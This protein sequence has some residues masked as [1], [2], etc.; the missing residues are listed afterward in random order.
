MKT[1]NR[2]WSSVTLYVSQSQYTMAPENY[3]A[4]TAFIMAKQSTVTSVLSDRGNHNLAF[5]SRPGRLSGRLARKSPARLMCWRASRLA[6][7]LWR[8]SPLAPPAGDVC[9]KLIIYDAK[10]SVNSIYAAG[11][12]CSGFVSRAWG[13][14][15]RYT[16]RS[17]PSHLA[18]PCDRRRPRDQ[19]YV[20][21]GFVW[22]NSAP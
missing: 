4:E 7:Q 12:D 9:T 6:L 15:A 8:R 16:T 3:G 1:I 13:G 19:C 11:V 20:D 21:V 5:W 22:F 10:S 17:I 14:G 18:Q 2:R